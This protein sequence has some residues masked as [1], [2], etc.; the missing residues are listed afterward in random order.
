[1]PSMMSLLS[2]NQRKLTG[3]SLQT[4]RRLNI[5]NLRHIA[6][7]TVAALERGNY[8]APSG[9]M[10]DFAP[11]LKHCVENTHCYKPDALETI[12]EQVLAEP[13]T[14]STEFELVNETTLQGSARIV[15]S[16]KYQHIAVLNFASAKHPGGGFLG[17]A[18]AQEESLARSSG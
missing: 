15:E 13:P 3:T 8:T 12:R 14:A 18:K 16:G 5:L 4:S 2:G 11:L 10:V 9:N 6:E 1:H 17:G 7:E